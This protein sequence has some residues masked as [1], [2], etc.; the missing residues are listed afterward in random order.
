MEHQI[1][2]SSTTRT[3]YEAVVLPLPIS[4]P[5]PVH[6]LKQGQDIVIASFVRRAVPPPANPMVHVSPKVSVE[7]FHI[8]VSEITLD[9][10]LTLEKLCGV[11]T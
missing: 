9:P 7:S 2:T 3:A 5:T 8:G 6:T 11:D 10:M 4:D 1:H